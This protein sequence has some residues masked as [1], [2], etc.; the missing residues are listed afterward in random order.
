M[1]HESND[2][3]ASDT[4]P[5]FERLE[6]IEFDAIVDFYRAAPDAVREQHALELRQIGVATCLLSRGLEPASIFRR[7]V[8]V[9]VSEP[10]DER[11]LDELLAFMNTFHGTYAVPVAPASRP[12]LLARWLTERGFAPGY[13]WMKFR[14]ALSMTSAPAH[15]DDE[16]AHQQGTTNLD[17]RVVDGDDARNFGDVITQGFGMPPAMAPWIARLPGRSGWICLMAF[18]KKLPVAAGCAFLRDGYAWLGLGATLPSHRR[19]GAQSALLARRLY[20]AALKGA[21]VAVTET[22][23]RLPDKPSNS[24]RNIVRAGFVEMYV[25]QNY[26]S[27]P[28]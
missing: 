10:V 11:A 8:N 15:D 17:V 19:L 23:E 22:G 25:R 24:Y 16:F 1:D 4:P 5:D 2:R 20:E 6:Q 12:Q 28:R 27:S 9:G 3:N 26:L 14:R 7:I 18:E 13:A 21:R